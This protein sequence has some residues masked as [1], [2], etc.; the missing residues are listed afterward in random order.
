[1][2]V[3]RIF[4]KKS[5]NGVIEDLELVQDSFNWRG[6]FLGGFYLLFKRIWKIALVVL[7]VYAAEVALLAWNYSRFT[8][9]V[10][11]LDVIMA[12]YIGFEYVDWHSK[13]LIKRGYEYLGYSSGRD[14]REAKLKFLENVNKDN[15]E[16]NT[17]TEIY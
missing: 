11:A 4:L 8:A 14:V 10:S 6:F 5:P 12:V 15:R 1:M 3:Y 16:K 17:A 7:A 13:L 9:F 2:R